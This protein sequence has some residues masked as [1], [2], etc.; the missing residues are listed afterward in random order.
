[1]FPWIVAGV[2]LCLQVFSVYRT[3]R[4]IHGEIRDL[5]DFKSET[6][7]EDVNSKIKYRWSTWVR[8]AFLNPKS[9]QIFIDRDDAFKELDWRVSCCVWL[10]G[11]QRLGIAAPLVGV[12]ITAIG[13]WTL[14]LS[15]E[16]RIGVPE[17]MKAIRPVSFGILIGGALS[18]INQIFLQYIESKVDRFCGYAHDWFDREV[19]PKVPRPEESK[20]TKTLESL[21]ITIQQ[22][23]RIAETQTRAIIA[24]EELKSQVERSSEVIRTAVLTFSDHW[25]Q[26]VDSLISISEKVDQTTSRFKDI[27]PIGERITDELCNSV[28]RFAYLVEHRYEERV[29]LQFQSAESLSESV[30]LIGR[31]IKQFNDESQKFV[32]LSERQRI[33]FGAFSDFFQNSVVPSQTEVSRTLS[34]FH[35]AVESMTSRISGVDSSLHEIA[36][37][38]RVSIHE[39]LLPANRQI[40][41][42]ADEM[43]NIQQNA[44]ASIELFIQDGVKETANL[45][46]CAHESFK[47][48]TDSIRKIHEFVEGPFLKSLE[49]REHSISDL[50]TSA[51]SLT[52]LVGNLNRTTLYLTNKCDQIENEK[53]VSSQSAESLR[54]A[55][56]E[57]N[58]ILSRIGS[59]IDQDIFG[60]RNQVLESLQLSRTSCDKALEIA[61]MV[62]ED[63]SKSMDLKN[64]EI[65][66]LRLTLEEFAHIHREWPS[67]I[68]KLNESVT[69]ISRMLSGTERTIH[70]EGDSQKESKSIWPFNINIR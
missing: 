45:S 24:S 65:I 8:S 43:R 62:Q 39:S 54:S 66:G 7:Y 58:T 35:S 26:S 37:S 61:K 9:S 41:S 51:E 2:F 28:A 30:M 47:T 11:L 49:M 52:E 70:K 25:R 36:E 22:S 13:F 63:R 23:R 44:S 56:G 33:Q 27:L 69:S 59:L 19:L 50:G 1:M 4:W 18:L 67:S 20:L 15:T 60:M 53:N 55:T 21:E 17:V 64:Q 3:K 34:Q 57:L 48:M 6:P 29:A 32:S 40:I 42:V 46:E 38:I 14:D 16:E 10:T 68:Q 31:V 5:E 12:I